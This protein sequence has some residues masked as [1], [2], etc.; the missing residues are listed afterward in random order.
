MTLVIISMELNLTII[1]SREE[2]F[3]DRYSEL[4]KLM[5][6]IHEFYVYDYKIDMLILL[7][8]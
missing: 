7:G 5:N 1:Y 4:T 3:L 2:M 8:S 6:V